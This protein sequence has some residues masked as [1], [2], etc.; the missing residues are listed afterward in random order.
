MAMLVTSNHHAVDRAPIAV[1]YMEILAP[2]TFDAPF[3][4]DKWCMSLM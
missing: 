2:M 3:N 4:A 1:D